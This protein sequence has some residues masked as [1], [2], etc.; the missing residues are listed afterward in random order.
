MTDHAD[1]DSD[2]M[3]AVTADVESA[4]L[5]ALMW[6]TPAVAAAAV[7]HVEASDFFQ[8]SATAVFET[9]TTLV[10]HQRPAD[11]TF[12]LAELR[13]RGDAVNARHLTAIVRYLTETAAMP[14]GAYIEPL[15]AAGYGCEVTA[16]AYRRAFV[17]AAEQINESAHTLGEDDLWEAMCRS[18]RRIRDMRDRLTRARS[19]FERPPPLQWDQ[20]SDV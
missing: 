17:L 3:S 18:G 10:A 9:I 6:A 2:D 1:S 13:R 4:Y 12:V 11:P 19:A 8:P 7:E 14:R 20:N 16:M 15:R 5:C